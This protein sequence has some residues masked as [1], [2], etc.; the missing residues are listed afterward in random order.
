M[1]WRTNLLKHRSRFPAPVATGAVTVYAWVTVVRWLYA[2]RPDLYDN[3]RRWHAGLEPV[4]KLTGRPASG[5]TT[6]PGR[7]AER[8]GAAAG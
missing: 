5:V 4:S 8:I 3:A 1:A 7:A 6:I 2:N